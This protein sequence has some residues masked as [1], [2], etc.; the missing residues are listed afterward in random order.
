MKICRKSVEYTIYFE[1]LSIYE[2]VR[3]LCFEI[4]S[5]FVVNLWAEIMRSAY[6]DNW[7][8]SCQP[9]HFDDSFLFFI[10][11]CLNP[12][13]SLP[14]L[15][16]CGLCSLQFACRGIYELR[17]DDVGDPVSGVE[18]DLSFIENL[19]TFRVSLQH[20]ASCW[21]APCPLCIYFWVD[22]NRTFLYLLILWLVDHFV[23]SRA[24]FFIYTATMYCTQTLYLVFVHNLLCFVIFERCNDI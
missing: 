8:M 9:G 14:A 11:C 16:W 6:T 20:L 10:A 13:Y 4:P 1:I 15:L 5:N 24:C 17:N 21:I 22:T 19:S 18:A 23:A 3:C 7:N 12:L 2:I